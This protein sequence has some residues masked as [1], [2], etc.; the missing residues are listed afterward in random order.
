MDINAQ[1][2]EKLRD[3]LISTNKDF[4]QNKLFLEFGVMQG[5]SLVDY[6]GAYMKYGI[7]AEF[8]GFDSFNGLP[9]E[10]LDKNSPWPTGKFGCGGTI[11]PNITAIPNLNLVEGWF[12]DTLNDSL[13]PRFGN[14]KIGLLH[15]D[16]DIYSA[17]VDVLEY[18]IQ[19]DLLCDGS[20]IVYDDWGAYLMNDATKHDEYSVAEA[21]A[22]K[23]ITEKYNLD[24]ELVSKEVIDPR[25]YVIATY[26]Y[27]KK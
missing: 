21:R 9:E 20:L 1:R 23:E 3:N 17:T 24:F 12:C 6:H 4:L 19:N 7:D 8:W 15:M 16:C 22:H 11:H 10:K 27:K 25:Y 18:V 13:T 5:H 2:K 26:R 14:K